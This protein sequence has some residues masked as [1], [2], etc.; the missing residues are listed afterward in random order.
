MTAA[1]KMRIWTIAAEVGRDA[2]EIYRRFS[3]EYELTAAVAVHA[4]ALC[5]LLAL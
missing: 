3:N 5:E 4:M 1:Q 2:T